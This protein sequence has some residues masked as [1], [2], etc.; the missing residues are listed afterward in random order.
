[1]HS[2]KK[3]LLS[4]HAK[5]QLKFRGTTEEEIFQSIRNSPWAHTKE[6]RWEASLDFSF[7]AIWNKK[8]YKTKRVRPIFVEE[9]ASIV[10]VTV[11]VY[12]IL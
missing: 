7:N 1:M 4:E 2:Q 12:F 6:N 11:Y 5:Q 8:I 9:S 3:I 10:V